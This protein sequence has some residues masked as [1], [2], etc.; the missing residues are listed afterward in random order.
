MATRKRIL[1][2]CAWKEYRSDQFQELLWR[3]AGILCNGPHR[4][5]IDRRM[6][7]NRE[8][9][10]SVAHDH[11]SALA[12]NS[13]AELLKYL[14]SVALADSWNSWHRLDKYICMLNPLQPGILGLDLEPETN[15]FLDV[16]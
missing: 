13:I 2:K 10:P 12:S 15:C 11:V 6:P 5:G 8:A 7:G 16:C 14:N 9:D 1:H 3:E 4:Y